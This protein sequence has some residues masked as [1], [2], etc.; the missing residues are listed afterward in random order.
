MDLIP[1]E[2]NS[3]KCDLVVISRPIQMI[4]VDNSWHLRTFEVVFAD[5][6][7]SW[8][9]EIQEC[10]NKFMHCTENDEIIGEL[11]KKKLL[12]SAV[13][14]GLEPVKSTNEKKAGNKKVATQRRA[15]QLQGWRVKT[16]LKR[17]MKWMKQRKSKSQGCAGK[18]QKALQ[19]RALQRD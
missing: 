11:D 17:I 19:K 2:S 13:E 7:R 15:K 18:I 9:E 8:D 1:L 12:S 16:G 14:A 10:E 3:Y 5:L 4:E 6:H